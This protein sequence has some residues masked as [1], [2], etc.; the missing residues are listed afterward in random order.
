[1]VNFINKQI[2]EL[3][4]EGTP[5]D[6]RRKLSHNQIEELL[7]IYNNKKEYKLTNKQIADM[8]DVNVN[9]IYRYNHYEDYLKRAREDNKKCRENK[10]KEELRVRNI[11]YK[12][13]C[14]LY[15]KV[16]LEVKNMIKC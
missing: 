10:S 7:E 5:L 2:K 8:F 15:K 6:R 1:M 3:K 12:N 9:Q 16:L 14:N 4:I 11:K 13:S